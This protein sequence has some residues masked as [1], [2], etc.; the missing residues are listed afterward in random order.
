MSLIEKL[1]TESQEYFEK[2]VLLRTNK[3][4]DYEPKVLPQII[5]ENPRDFVVASVYDMESRKIHIP[6]E[7]FFIMYNNLADIKKAIN[8]S[9]AKEY[10]QYIHDALHGFKLLEGLKQYKSK[11]VSS[12]NYG[13]DDK[14]ILQILPMSKIETVGI[15]AATRI[16]P[17]CAM[18]FQ[19]S[20]DS[21]K[22]LALKT[23]DVELLKGE[24][25]GLPQFFLSHFYVK[26]YK[27]ISDSQFRSLVREKPF[28]IPQQELEESKN[29]LIQ[30]INNL[31]G[32]WL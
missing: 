23:F 27:N 2:D 31:Y 19:K 7:G 10:A 15:L 29:F 32:P 9:F 16:L 11:I 3:L 17:D 26:K 5:L 1:K 8:F 14:V 25:Y 24:L 22:E 28:P 12:K 4:F 6:V 18:L 20:F 30:E 21:A 13:D